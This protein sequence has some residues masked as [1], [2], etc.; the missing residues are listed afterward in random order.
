MPVFLSNKYTLKPMRWQVVVFVGSTKNEV[1]LA[2]DSCA[3][4]T[5]VVGFRHGSDWRKQAQHNALTVNK[6][7]FGYAY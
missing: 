3:G 2:S 5:L 1:T 6:A 4:S 7:E